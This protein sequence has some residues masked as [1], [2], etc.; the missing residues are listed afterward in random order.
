MNSSFILLSSISLLV[1]VHL[2]PAVPTHE[3]TAARTAISKSASL[4]TLRE[5]I[6]YFIE[7]QI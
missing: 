5:K 1:V 3:N 2:W 7:L 4:A 6:K